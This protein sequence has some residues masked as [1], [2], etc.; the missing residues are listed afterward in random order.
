MALPMVVTH[1]YTGVRSCVH[2]CYQSVRTVVADCV[3]PPM[4]A[5]C[6][7]CMNERS[8]LC[9]TCTAKIQPVVSMRLEITATK[10]MWVFAVSA[11]R[12]PLKTLILAKGYSDIVAARQLGQLMWDMTYIKNVPFD[13]IVAVPTH[14]SRFAR[15]GFNQS[16]EMAKIIARESGKPLL[17]PLKR[18]KRTQFQSSLDKTM[19]AQNVHEAFE[20]VSGDWG[21]LQDKKI[22]IVDDLFTTGA[23]MK[24]MARVLVRAKPASL[25]AVVACRVV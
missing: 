9:E 4:C 6:R 11:Y 20:W 8:V 23:T 7:L 13:Y 21:F 22:L 10:D 24:E 2:L 16:L 1:L 5:Y 12:D 18:A 19:R 17:Q 3:T 14:W 15:R 25:V